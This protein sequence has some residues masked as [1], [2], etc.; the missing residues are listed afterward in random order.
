MLFVKG[1]KICKNI[2][3]ACVVRI[4]D[5]EDIVD[6]TEMVYDQMFFVRCAMCTASMYVQIPDKI[7]DDGA[8]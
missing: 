6:I 1:V 5:E 2:L 8:P 7:P 3:C 4:K